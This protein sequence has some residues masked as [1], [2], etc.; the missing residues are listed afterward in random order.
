MQGLN[1]AVAHEN[2]KKTARAETLTIAP[3]PE[4]S[5]SD[6]K[7]IRLSLNMTQSTFAA[8]MGVS[9]KTVESWEK[10][11]NIPAGTA[12]RMM[13]ML[14]ADRSIPEKYHIISR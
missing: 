10:G 1:E 13:S 8:V 14:K 3:L 5:A 12:R 4:I 7:E 6:V 9:H 11:T 2:G